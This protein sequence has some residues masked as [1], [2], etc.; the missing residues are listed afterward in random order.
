MK[1]TRAFIL[2]LLVAALVLSA[3]CAGKRYVYNFVSENSLSRYDGTWYKYNSNYSFSSG[4]L[5]NNCYVATPHLY[6]GDFT[7][8]L[9][10]RLDASDSNM[11]MIEFYL[12]TQQSWPGSDYYGGIVFHSL[13]TDHPTISTYYSDNGSFDWVDEDVSI[14]DCINDNGMNTVR[15]IK[16]GN[17]LDFEVNSVTVAS[18]FEMIGVTTWMFIPH[19]YSGGSSGT[20]P[21]KY[22]YFEVNYK[23][24]QY[25]V[26]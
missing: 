20:S 1:Y 17:H 26:V 23:G 7:V 3:G 22:T 12:C 14:A 8:L 18:D 5:L 6:D 19:I 25:P 16:T 2:A 21:I 9:N 15:I 10:F 13:G 24:K 4:L 11:G